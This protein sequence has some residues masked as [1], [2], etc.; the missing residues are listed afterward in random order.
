M[1][2]APRLA[3]VRHR[4]VGHAQEPEL[5]RVGVKPC[6]VVTVAAAAV[7]T[8]VRDARG[9]GTYGPEIRVRQVHQATAS[10]PKGRG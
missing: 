5:P 10:A 7:P 9:L 2:V 8:D 3:A 6:A 4:R 1:G